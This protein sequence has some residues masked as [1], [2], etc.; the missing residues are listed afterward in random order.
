M[1]N[2]VA[3]NITELTEMNLESITT[4]VNGEIKCLVWPTF[5]ALY[6]CYIIL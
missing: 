5:G 1:N 6:L 2:N 3:S 4:Q